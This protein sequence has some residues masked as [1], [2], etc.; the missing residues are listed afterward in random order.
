MTTITENSLGNLGRAR[1]RAIIKLPTV[2]LNIVLNILLIP[3]LG[4]VGAALATVVSYGLFTIATMYIMH[5]ELG[6]RIRYLGRQT[7]I[8]SIITVIMAVA[9]AF[10]LQFVSGLFSLLFVVFFG[11]IIWGLLALLSG[12]LGQDDLKGHLI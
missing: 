1:A 10:G 5:T 4:V 9:V 6:L 2:G 8:I 3:R 7:M 11:T 12:I